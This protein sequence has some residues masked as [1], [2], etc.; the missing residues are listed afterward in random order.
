MKNVINYLVNHLIKSYSVFN[1]FIVNVLAVAAPLT[2]EN[3]GIVNAT[4]GNV[5]E[6]NKASM[7]EQKNPIDQK[8]KLWMDFDD[9]FVCFKYY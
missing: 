2:Q 3:L 4:D 9:F 5:T 6:N 1:I 7:Q 8:S